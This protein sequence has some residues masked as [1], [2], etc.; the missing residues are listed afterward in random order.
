M[1]V[2]AVA[3][4]SAWMADDVDGFSVTEYE[5]GTAFS[6]LCE[7]GSVVSSRSV[8]V[9]PV[10]GSTGKSPKAPPP[11]ADMCVRLKPVA[12]GAGR[13]VRAEREHPERRDRTGKRVDL[14][15]HIAAGTGADHRVDQ[16]GRIADD[17]PSRGRAR[18]GPARG[19]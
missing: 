5:P 15:D 13:G 19:G 11:G 16:R 18:G 8:P 9:A 6:S 4:R 3:A 7:N 14:P 12:E 1:P 10:V 2:R 17:R